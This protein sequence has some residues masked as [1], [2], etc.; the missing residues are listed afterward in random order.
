MP[1]PNLEVQDRLSIEMTKYRNQWSSMA[2][3]LLRLENT[4]SQLKTW[5]LK[6]SVPKGISLDSLGMGDLL[7]LLNL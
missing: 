4:I 5:E 1:D 3:E 6:E 2:D 7:K